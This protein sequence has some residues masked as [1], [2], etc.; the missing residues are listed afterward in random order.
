MHFVKL[1]GLVA[2]FVSGT[3]TGVLLTGFERR[4]YRQAEGFV[5]LVRHIRLQIDCFSLPVERILS[6]LDEGL[7][8]DCALPA[9]AASFPAL[10]QGTR[11]FLPPE[12]RDLL[13]GFS[14]DLGASYREDQLRCCD[15]YLARLMPHCERIREELPRKMRLWLLLPPALSGALILMLI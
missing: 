8:A 13:I 11:L 5:A 6:T 12:M 1:L 7:R 4:R 15:Y 3:V 2:L 14:A 9:R 10:L